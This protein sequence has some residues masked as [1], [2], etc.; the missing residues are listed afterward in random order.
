VYKKHFLPLILSTLPCALSGQT[1]G[2][3]YRFFTNLGNIDVVLTPSVA[4]VTVANFISYVNAGAYVN[5][6]IARSVPGFVIQGGGYQLVTSSGTSTIV[7]T[8]TNASIVNEFNV[9]NTHGTIA[10]AKGTD[11]N[12]AT[13]QWFFNVVDN[14]GSPNLL[15]STA[16]GYTV[17]GSTNAAGLK[18]ITTINNLSTISETG[19]PN[20]A[21]FT[22]CP[23]S[24]GNFV[25]VTSISPVP[26]LTAPG[27]LSAA[28]YASNS[29]T[30]IAPGEI[31]AI[32]GQGMG[33]TTPVSATVTNGAL[34]TSLAGVQ[35]T[36]NGRAA[37]L[38]FVS[39]NQINVIAPTNFSALPSVDIIV[40]Y[41]NIASNPPL[42]FP[43][44]PANPAVFTQNGAGTG[45]GIIFQ[46]NYTLVTPAAPAA[47]GDN[48]FLYGEG[49]GLATSG[50]TLPDGAIVGNTP[51]FPVPNDPTTLLLID[52]QAVPTAYF[53]GAP[54]LANG[55]LQVNFT[56]PQLKPGSHQ[57]QLQVGSRIGPTG[58][59]LQTK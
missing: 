18:V 37:P 43:V 1:P 14:G 56:V 46:S 34:P 54:G 53:G 50:T 26:V 27:V 5:S 51:P 58:V 13:S 10:M 57:I 29:L 19:T 47:A 36:F 2:P 35:V 24:G 28:S 21:S 55:V 12:S 8:P 48:L 32:F 22:N 3:T 23:L 42:V 9:S 52:G 33:P 20:D 41:N 15:D 6:I 25:L 11:P 49:Y 39:A 44:K 30:G 31:I 45:D 7:T 40:T 38:Y 16:G 4:P 17:F 59:T